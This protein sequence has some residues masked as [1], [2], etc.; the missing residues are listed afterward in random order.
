MTLTQIALDP[1]LADPVLL[2]QKRCTIRKGLRDY[3]LGLNRIVVVGTDQEIP[4]V[5][6]EVRHKL[7]YQVTEEEAQSDGYETLNLLYDCLVKFYPDLSFDDLIT[8]VYFRLAD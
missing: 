7:L 4:I 2:G 6:E 3:E 8:I 5:I 1:S